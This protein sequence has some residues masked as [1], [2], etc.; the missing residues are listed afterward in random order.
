MVNQPYPFF[1]G[2]PDELRNIFGIRREVPLTR[3]QDSAACRSK[4]EIP[5]HLRDAGR[6][7]DSKRRILKI[8]KYCNYSQLILLHFFNYLLFS[9]GT[10][11][12]YLTLT[13]T[14]FAK[15]IPFY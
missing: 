9:F 13:G 14:I 6:P 1:S 2:T 3:E 15:K 5:R 10:V 7:T 4:A 12:K 11:C 8:L